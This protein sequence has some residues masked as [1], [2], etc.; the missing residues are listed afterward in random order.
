MIKEFLYF[1]DKWYDI[2]IR[3]IDVSFEIG[4]IKKG[5]NKCCKKKNVS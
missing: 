3:R 1:E 2:V 4:T 5:Y